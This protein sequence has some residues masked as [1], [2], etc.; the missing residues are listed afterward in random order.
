M[1]KCH[2]AKQQSFY[3]I[4]YTKPKTTNR[5]K[6]LKTI[7]V[8]LSQTAKFL[9]LKRPSHKKAIKQM[10]TPK[11][12]KYSWRI[13]KTYPLSM[14]QQYTLCKYKPVIRVSSIQN[15]ANKRQNLSLVIFPTTKLNAFFK[16]IDESHWISH[17]EGVWEYMGL[18][19]SLIDDSYIRVSHKRRCM[20]GFDR[21][22][23]RPVD[24]LTRSV[25]M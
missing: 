20:S 3:N 21:T 12:Q 6:E 14:D 19:E 16:I 25:K 4:S 15:S 1:S 5:T 18:S 17:H 11:M 2:Q 8:S 23:I 24:F 22:C 7:L 9:Q 13:S 10:P